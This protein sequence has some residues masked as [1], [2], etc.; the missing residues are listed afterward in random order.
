METHHSTYLK[1][2]TIPLI[3]TNSCSIRPND[4][5]KNISKSPKIELINNLNEEEINNNSEE[6]PTSIL[7]HF[8]LAQLFATLTSATAS[9]QE[10]SD[11]FEEGNNDN[12][13]VKDEKDLIEE[14]K[15]NIKN[16]EN[17]L[18]TN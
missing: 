12:N 1:R 6:S 3:E 17:I 11:E 18:F 2:T 15:N 10:S 9:I 14:N 13:K 16:T 5:R 4:L 7:N 8:E